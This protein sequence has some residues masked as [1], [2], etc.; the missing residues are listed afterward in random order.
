MS[1]DTSTQTQTPSSS[2]AGW[3][4]VDIFCGVG[5]L[6]H[7]F[8]LENFNVVAGLDSDKSCQFPYEQNNK[9]KFIGK[10]IEELELGEIAKLYPENSTRILVGCA[11][12]QP[13]SSNNVKRPDNDKWT[14]LHKFADLVEEIQ[15]IVFSMENVL[16]LKTFRDGEVF[17]TFIARLKK[18]GYH[19]TDYRAYCP[20]Y[21]IPQKRRR[22]VIFGSKLGPIQLL[23]GEYKAGKY[24]TVRDVL[25]DLKPIK[26]GQRNPS[27][28]LHRAA[29]LTKTNLK[30]IKISKPGGTWKDWPE[31]LRLHCHTRNKEET[32]G[33]T[34]LS[35]YG[36]MSWDEPAPTLTTQFHNLGSGR[37]GHPEQPRAITLREGAILQTF[38]R[39]YKF[40]ESEKDVNF[41]KL[42]RQIG[43]AV[44]VELGRAIAKSIQ[45]HL[46]VHFGKEPAVQND[47]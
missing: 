23:E 15:P 5:G 22:L 17:N 44:P 24:K 40:V 1:M 10:K 2:K 35:V 20:E 4:V 41:A 33:H 16:Q 28:L 29:G 14:L 8:V 26:A 37:Y 45:M 42:A 32:K 36:R 27:D 25:A 43:N 47:H 11:P 19:I 46:E 31:E 9:A 39:D 18:L 21:G 12:C 7:G 6:S 34:A 30:R 13:F 38:P 3:S